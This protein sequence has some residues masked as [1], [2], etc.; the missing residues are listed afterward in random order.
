VDGLLP[1]GSHLRL[2]YHAPAAGNAGIH[3]CT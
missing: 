3:Q 2:R 1:E